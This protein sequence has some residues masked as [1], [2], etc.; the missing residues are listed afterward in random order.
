MHEISR[1]LMNS[2]FEEDRWTNAF[3]KWF[4]YTVASRVEQDPVHPVYP[5]FTDDW[6]LLLKGFPITE[7]DQEREDME[8]VDH[9]LTSQNAVHEQLRVNRDMA[10]REQD[11]RRMQAVWSRRMA[12]DDYDIQS[13]G[14]APTLEPH[15][16]AQFVPGFFPPRKPQYEGNKT[17]APPPPPAPPIFPKTYSFAITN[18][19]EGVLNNTSHKTPPLPPIDV[20]IPPSSSTSTST[21]TITNPTNI[22]IP[23]PPVNPVSHELNS[24]KVNV[25]S[26]ATHIHLPVN[27]N[28][29][30]VDHVMKAIAKEEQ[31]TGAPFDR[32]L[33]DQRTKLTI[34]MYWE[35]NPPYP[36]NKEES[37][38]L[39][40]RAS[41]IKNADLFK[42]L[43]G[44]LLKVEGKT[45]GA[46]AGRDS[47]AFLK[48][49]K[50]HAFKLSTRETATIMNTRVDILLVYNEMDPSLKTPE[51]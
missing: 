2:A 28:S 20:V 1:K 29:N 11:E 43:H 18:R 40:S 10:Q 32:A 33:F 44:E 17:I 39:W 19:R 51:L 21:T 38:E 48:F 35:N 26:N 16:N 50:E 3:G 49:L 6:E 9:H 34:D 27:F 37:I 4:L 46:G 31:I 15:G 14:P 25:M 12:Y 42:W 30:H 47:T 23:T 41:P 5:V 13:A 22:I 45:D 36:Y 8:W 24:G 7:W